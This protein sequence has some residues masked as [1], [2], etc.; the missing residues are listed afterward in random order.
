MAKEHSYASI[1]NTLIEMMKDRGLENSG[2]DIGLLCYDLLEAAASEAEVWGISI[3]EIGLQ[4]FDTNKL[5]QSGGV[6][7]KSI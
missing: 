6:K 5:L 2:S 3:E 1:L 4:G 7:N